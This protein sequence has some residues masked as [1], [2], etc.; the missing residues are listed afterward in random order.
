MCV[1]EIKFVPCTRKSTTLFKVKNAYVDSV[2]CVT[3][4]KICRFDVLVVAHGNSP[5]WPVKAADCEDST[6]FGL[7]Q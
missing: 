6:L 2:C 7:T 3:E 1:H 4:N 5:S